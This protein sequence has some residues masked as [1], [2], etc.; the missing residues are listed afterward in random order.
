M[1]WSGEK[2]DE[3]HNYFWTIRVRKTVRRNLKLLTMIRVWECFADFNYSIFIPFYHW[4]SSCLYLVKVNPSIMFRIYC[5]ISP[6]EISF[7]VKGRIQIVKLF[8]TLMGFVSPDVK[9]TSGPGFLSNL[10]YF[11]L[12]SFENSGE[13]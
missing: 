2:K 7:I 10:Y 1:R 8:T 3:N 4:W 9:K 6:K 13:T 5:Y 11:S 12:V